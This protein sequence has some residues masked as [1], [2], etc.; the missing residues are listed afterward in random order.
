MRNFFNIITIVTTCLLVAGSV[1]AELHDRGGGLLY[2]DVLKVTWL[3]DANYAKTSSAHPTGK[4]SWQEANK[5]L[6]GLVYHDAVRNQDLRGWRL[7]KVKPMGKEFSYLFRTNGTADEGY[8]I[9]GANSEMGH[10]YYRNLMLNGWY[11]MDGKH[12]SSF[13]VLGLR[14]ATWSGQADIGLTRNVQSNIYWSASSDTPA[15]AR[16]AWVFVTAEGNQRDGLP[17]PN[18]GFVWAVRDGDVGVAANI[19]KSKSVNFQ[20]AR[21]AVANMPGL[22]AFWT[23]AED[24]GEKRYS[25]GTQNILPLLEVGGEIPRVK[26]G[27]FSGYSAHFDGSHY[28][29]IPAREMG[30]LNIS[31]KDAQ[32]SMF[33]VVKLDDLGKHGATIA[34]I[35][36]EGQGAGDDT[37]TRQYAMLLNMPAYGGGKQLTPHISSEGGVSRR[38]DGTALPWCAD[39]AAS[40]SEVPVGK[41]VT[42]G[43]TYD[44]KYIRAYYNGIM[45]KREMDPEKDRRADRYF[46]AEGPNGGYRGMNPYYHGRGIFRYDPTLHS[47]S[48]PRGVPDFTV[49]A[50]YAGGNMLGE[51]LKGQIGGLAVFNRALTDEEMKRLHDA[52]NIATLD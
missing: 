10:M 34:G 6:S 32:V 23:F 2:D 21:N 44:G 37:G 7:P 12:P 16:D 31:G 11:L 38:T 26:G 5:W 51:A 1:S 43:F 45:E 40:R 48:K 17:H 25:I 42:L 9:S 52:A 36:S 50:R 18:Q 47:K 19:T 46:T 15:P 30:P 20:A 14:A 22:V 8:N 13:G 4:M 39:F 3:Q 29:R 41:W 49:G 28:F 35:W 33:T 27:S 24:P